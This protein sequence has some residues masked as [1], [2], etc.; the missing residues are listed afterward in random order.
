MG[1]IDAEAATPWHVRTVFF[2][3][4]APR[5]LAFYTEK[6]GFSL[7]WTHGHAGRAFVFQVSFRGIELIVNEA[8]DW[9]ANRPGHGRVFVG[10]DDEQVESFQSYL[11]ERGIETKVLQ[12]G[13]PTVVINDCDGNEMFFWLSESERAKLRGEIIRRSD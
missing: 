9:T 8:E 12:W 1:L 11:E 2:V 4:D 10:L 6:L 13:E 7:D 3:R 5:A